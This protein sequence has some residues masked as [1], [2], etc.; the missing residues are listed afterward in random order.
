MGH[1]ITLGWILIGFIATM[2]I[3][4]MEVVLDGRKSLKWGH[5]VCSLIGS[6]TG[7][8]MLIFT[9]IFLIHAL[10]EGHV[11]VNWWNKTVYRRKRND[12]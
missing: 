11:R 10:F 12:D 8:I 9:G 3:F 1:L 4:Y 2:A 6:L 7:P 5:I